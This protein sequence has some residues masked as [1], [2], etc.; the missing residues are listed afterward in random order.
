MKSV[1]RTN[2]RH[3]FTVVFTAWRH[4]D[5]PEG[6]GKK[7]YILSNRFHIIIIFPLFLLFFLFKRLGT[8]RPSAR[9]ARIRSGR[10][11]ESLNVSGSL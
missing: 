6:C 4:A 7:D 3:G 9:R 10:V 11:Y 5:G 1:L 2:F 8:L